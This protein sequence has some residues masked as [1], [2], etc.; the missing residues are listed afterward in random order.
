MVASLGDVTL[1][2]GIHV[3]R[4]Q[5]GVS[6]NRK[7]YIQKLLIRYGLQDAKPSTVPLDPGFIQTKEEQTEAL[8]N[9]RQFSSL[10]GGLLCI[11]V[12]TRPDSCCSI[13]PRT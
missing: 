10:I 9:N 4:S 6:L 13:E 2:L 12:N 5:D 3:I 1:F 8:P 11:A 7:A